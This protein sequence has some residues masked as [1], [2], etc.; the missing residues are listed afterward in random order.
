MNPLKKLAG[1]TVIYGFTTILGRFVN[2]LLVPLYAGIFA[3]SEYGIVINLM[4][5]TA[6]LV[7][8]LT[9]GTE[10][11]FFRF[12]TQENQNNVFSTLMSSLS[13]TTLLFLFLTLFFLTDLS[14]F[15]DV[16]EHK[17]YLILL[18]VTIAIDVISSIPFAL[19]RLESRPIRF[20]IIKLLN[21][22][23][24]IGLNLFF[25]LCCPFLEKKGM[26]VPFF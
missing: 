26:H 11:G 13:V 18:I 2:W 19:L 8:L 4:S 7:V 17:E 23:I 15:L 5:Y 25:L 3:A 21:I 20:G 16:Q 9:Y 22:G 10:T 14:V 6:L 12:A 24:N 1:E